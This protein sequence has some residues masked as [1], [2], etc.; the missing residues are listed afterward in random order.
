MPGCQRTPSVAAG[1]STRNSGAHRYWLAGG[2]SLDLGIERL[3]M[4]T[5]TLPV[6]THQPN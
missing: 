1:V 4:A 2:L 3:F 6:L 5:A